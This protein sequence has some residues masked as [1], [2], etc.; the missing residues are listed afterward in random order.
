MV[1]HG[2]AS[3]YRGLQAKGDETY[4]PADDGITMVVDDEYFWAIDESINDSG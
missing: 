2:D 3:V 1:A 4:N